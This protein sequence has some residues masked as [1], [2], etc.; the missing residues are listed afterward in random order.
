MY[1]RI[2]LVVVLATVVA[3]G[4]ASCKRQV[5]VPSPGSSSTSA[6]RSGLPASMAALGDSITSAFGSC[7]TLAVCQSNSW[8]TGSGTRVNSH[9][10][11]I[12]AGNPA[13]RGHAHNYAS[14]GAQVADLPDQAARAVAARVEYVTVLIGAN[15]AC[16]RTVDDMT[17]AATFRT[18]LD[19]ALGVLKK[20]LPN[21]RVLVLSIPDLYRVWQVGH[22]DKHAISAWNLLG[23]CHSML[24]NPTSTTSVDNN[25]RAAVRDRVDAYDRAL[26]GA[27]RS[28]G[29]HCRY[30]DGAVHRATFS[31]AQLN[32]LDFFHPNTDGQNQ[33]ASTSYPARF[34]W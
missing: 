6:A 32:Q 22:A 33:L 20:G 18:T 11:R 28:Y 2:V 12:L 19:Q 25:R 10:R 15:D 34:T 26:A 7:F 24:A 23:I 30:D 9:Y 17:S 1:R 5:G 13:I 31:L 21:A 16:R 8:S 4:A 27:C 29:R 3:L 14:A